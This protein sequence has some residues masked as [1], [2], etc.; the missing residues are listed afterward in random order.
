[1][2]GRPCEAQRGDGQLY[3][4]EGTQGDRPCRACIRGVQPLDRGQW[5][6]AVPPLWDSFRSAWGTTECQAAGCWHGASASRGCGGP[7]SAG[8]AT[9]WA[10]LWLWRLDVPD[11]LLACRWPGEGLFVAHHGGP[12]LMTS[13]NSDHLPPHLLGVRV[14]CMND[15]QDSVRAQI[16]CSRGSAWLTPASGGVSS[17]AEP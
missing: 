12:T 15:H 9:G 8:A 17:A 6:C 2:E 11:Q 5:S 7:S 3:D 16:W 13:S 14:N 10:F 4:Q 1:M